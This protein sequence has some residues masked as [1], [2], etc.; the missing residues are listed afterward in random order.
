MIYIGADHGGFNLKKKIIE[1]LTTAKLP[2]KD[3]GAFKLDKDDDY[4]NY[5]TLVAKAVQKDLKNN[6]GIMICRTGI[7]SALVANKFKGIRSGVGINATF[8]KKA[9]EDNG[10]N[11]LALPGDFL[12]P[13]N[14]W[15]IVKRFL[16]TK[17]LIK[18]R[19]VRRDKMINKLEK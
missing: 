5:V 10:I 17:T 4:V 12:D 16:N 9:R 18:P 6:M 7:G 11:I 19:Y 13:S 15:L 3:V 8:A 14:A 2:F 1:F